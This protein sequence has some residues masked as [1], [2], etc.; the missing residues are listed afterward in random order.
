[1]INK[2]ENGGNYL[3]IQSHIN[4]DVFKELEHNKLRTIYFFYTYEEWSKNGKSSYPDKNDLELLNGYIKDHKNI[5]LSGIENW[6]IP[7]LSE[8]ERFEF[9]KCE[10]DINESVELMKNNNARTLRLTHG[11]DKKYDLINFLAFKDTLEELSL[12]D[13]SYG[14][15]K[16]IEIIINEMKK[17]KKLEVSS[18]KIDFNL[19][20]ESS[21]EDLYYYGSKDKRMGWFSKAA[22][23]KIFRN[24]GFMVVFKN[25]MFPGFKRIKKAK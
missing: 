25:K 11:P 5:L 13:N 10:E 14:R 22:K 17:L 23:I 6:W 4:N 21:I 7:L 2:V 3:K 1:M 9:N 19:I 20:A 8:L 15:Y 12:D 18:M 24:I 16:S